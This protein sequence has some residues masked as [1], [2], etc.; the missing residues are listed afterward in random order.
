MTRLVAIVAL[1]L[2]AGCMGPRPEIPHEA[3]V[4]PPQ[5]WRSDPGAALSDISAAWWQSFADPA[6]ARVVETALAHNVDVALA[7]ERVAEARGQYHFAQAQRWPDVTGLAAGDRQRDVNPGFGV[8][9]NQTPG[10]AEISISYDLDLFG[11]LSEASE[12]ARAQLLSS[13]A[14]GDNVRLAVAAS[15]A[16]GYITLRALDARLDVLRRTLADRADSFRI[17]RRRAETGYASQLDLAQAE[18]DYRTAEQQIPAAQLAI[19]RQEDGLSILLGDNPRA[20]ERGLDLGNI[21]LPSV[22]VAVPAALMRRRPDIIA[23][24]EQLVAADHALDSARAAFLPDIRISADG[25][26]V[27]STLISS[28]VQVFTLGAGIFGP[29]FDAGRLDAQQETTAA[30]RN[31]A[32]FAYRKTALGAFREVEDSLAAIRR[33]DEQEQA[34]TKQR[35]AVARALRLATNRYRAGYSPYLD[36]LDAERTLLTTELALVQVRSDRLNA[37]VTLYQALGGGWNASA[38]AGK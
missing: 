33:L 14:A 19:A 30:R 35:D 21:A 29:I 8:P 20:V 28:P 10:E 24:E 27:G 31:Q 5:A 22:P 3:A 23:A 16:G 37:A 4:V 17:A 1:V 2:L 32:A 7:A 15:A 26:L 34:L 18:A 6:L 12:A 38:D 11:R 13:V 36:Q 25:G 9:E